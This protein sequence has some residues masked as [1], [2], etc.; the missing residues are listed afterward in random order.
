[1]IKILSLAAAACLALVTTSVRARSPFDGRW[2]AD[3]DTQSGLAT[4]MYLV[5]D[6]HYACSSCEPPRSYAAD[7]K[8]HPVAGD[9]ETTSESVTITGRRSIVTHIIGP[10]LD[11]VT[12]MTVAPDD[13]TASYVSVDHRPGI[14]AALRT[15]YLAR[16]T[17]AAPAGAH[18][19]SGTWQGVRYVQ[20]PE[21]VR[22]TT[23]RLNGNR[24]SYSTPLGT[25]Y[26]AHLGG[27]DVPVRTMQGAGIT[28]SVRLTG[29]RRIEEKVKR[30]G[31]LVE[32]RTFTLAP[33]GR[34]M[35]I[36]TRD[37]AQGA[38][39]RAISRR[40]ADQRLPACSSTGRERFGSTNGRPAKS[41]LQH[42]TG[43]Q[44]SC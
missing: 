15:E 25:S 8:P 37:P 2:V 1:M 44:R 31:Q 34:S 20:V 33:N 7:G 38:T 35:E 12:T 21:L 13:R 23:L 24:F 30:D 16:R 39:F 29:K 4:D 18:A 22:T 36:A 42:L 17:A 26:T 32:V 6:G 3:L 11:R 14:T 41:A 28:A 43:R 10:P 9:P 5:R 19:V 27:G 40:A